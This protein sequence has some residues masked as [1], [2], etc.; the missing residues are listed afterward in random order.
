MEVRFPGPLRQMWLTYNGV[1]LTRGR[2]RVF[3]VFDRSSPRKTSI[4]VTYQNTKGR[5]LIPAGYLSIAESLTGSGNRLV[6][7]ISGN[8]AEGPILV[9]EYK[10]GKISPWS[11]G[12]EDFVA[13]AERS[14]SA[15]RRLSSK[16]HEV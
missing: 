7:E 1:E 16:S 11:G 8:V 3:P 2:W 10:S 12:F 14:A 15:V 13:E 9:F 5:R 6:L 4:D